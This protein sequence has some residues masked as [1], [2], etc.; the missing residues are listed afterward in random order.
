MRGRTFKEVWDKDRQPRVLGE[1]VCDELGIRQPKTKEVACAACC[2]D[3]F[4]SCGGMKRKRVVQN[5]RSLFVALWTLGEVVRDTVKLFHLAFRTAFES[6]AFQAVLHEPSVSKIS[7]HEGC[8]CNSERR[9]GSTHRTRL[10]GSA[11]GRHV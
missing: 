1:P 6:I 9:A 11:R 4:R 2:Q 10:C 8:A 3:Q 7:D 5:D